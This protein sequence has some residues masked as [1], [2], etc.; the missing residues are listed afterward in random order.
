MPRPAN[1]DYITKLEQRAERINRQLR[2][3]RADNAKQARAEDTRRKIIEGALC[4]TH[5]LA[6]RR[7]D[8]AGVY[9]GLL[10]QYVR[11]EDRW[12]FADIFRALLPAAEAEKLLAD[13]EIARAAA[14][15]A[16]AEKRAARRTTKHAVPEAA[17]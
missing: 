9:V 3:A 11:L 4:E 12:L 17:E 2:K 16:K 5:A 13:G 8:F 6:N 15:K 10:K 1:P 7:S 14:D